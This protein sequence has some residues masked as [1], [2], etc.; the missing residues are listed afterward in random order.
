MIDPARE[1]TLPRMVAAAVARYG[2]QTAIEDGG[3]RLTFEELDAAGWR[4]ARAFLAE[5][6]GHGDRVAI[7]APNVAEWV[8][9]AIGAQR[10]GAV[11]VPISTRNKGA[12]TAYAL[13]KS[14]ARVLCTIAGFLDTD[15]VGML[16]GHELP[17]LERIIL[18][19]GEAPGAQRWQEFLAGGDRASEAEARARAQ[20]VTPD[21]LADMLFT[22]GTTGRPKGVLC[23]H[24]QNLEAFEV[25]SGWVGLREGDRY[26]VV[27]PFFHSFGYKAGWLS[28]LMRGATIYPH[29]VFDAQAVLRRIEREKITVLPGPPTIYQSL[30]AAPNLRDYDLSSL[31]LAVT[32]AAAIP[33][34]LVRRMRDELG[35]ATVLTAYGLTESCGVVSVCDSSDDAETIA[36]TSGKA[37][38]GTEV[39]CVDPDGKEV[40]RG[41]PGEIWVR[42]YNVM[43]GYFEAEEQTRE[44]IDAEGWLH[45]GDVGVMDERGYLRI[46]DRIKDMF[47]VGGFN[48]YPAEIENL[49]FANDAIA[50]VAVIGIPDARMGEV[51]MAFVVPAPGPAPTAAE[52]AAW[53]RDAMANYKV[54]RRIEIVPAL[55]VNAAGKVDKVELRRRAESGG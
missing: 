12:E 51:G 42:G 36:T 54:P 32:G 47:I 33:V 26:L 34:E 20:A 9:G 4:A 1:R 25:W 21:D 52:L 2:P 27:A 38:P 6:I 29:P 48:C 35:F 23:A 3:V 16:A 49:M 18:L 14:G 30:L 24:G 10:V 37:I 8:V 5:G 44:A 53:C 46:T 55:P 19:R 40:P 15:Y 50:E 11:L 43:R 39:R 45:T 22:S 7:W 28:A 17:A 13:G 31:R 41:Q